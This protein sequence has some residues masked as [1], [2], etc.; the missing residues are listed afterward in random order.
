MAAA[1]I[2]KRKKRGSLQKQFML[3]AIKVI[4]EK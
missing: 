2:A 4:A 1:T 3:S